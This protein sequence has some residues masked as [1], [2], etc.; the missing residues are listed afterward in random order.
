MLDDTALFPVDCCAM[1]QIRLNKLI[2]QSGLASRRKADELIAEGAVI[3]NGK[4]AFELGMQVDPE[5]DQITVKGKLLRKAPPKLYLMFNKPKQVVTTM[6]D[7][8][9]R[10]CISDFIRKI[11]VRVFPVG[12]LDWDSE[13]LILLTNDGE[14]AQKVAHP[15]LGIPKTYLVKVDAEP[16]P[17]QIQKLLRGVSIPSGR[18]KAQHI[19]KIER[20]STGKYCWLKVVIDEGQNRQIRFMFEKIG[21]DVLKLQRVSIGHLKLGK[22]PRG[23]FVRLSEG[24]VRL[25]FRPLSPKPEPKKQLEGKRRVNAP[26]SKK[27]KAYKGKKH[28]VL[29]PLNLD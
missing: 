9:G 22:L 4:K 16:R 13:G 8:Q 17:L 3:V 25:I 7:P 28:Q 29:K 26:L 18:A 20:S 6:E 10:P 5:N 12:R 24:D 11:P 15:K 27:A 14:F 1:S 23:E 21:L 2:S 19:E